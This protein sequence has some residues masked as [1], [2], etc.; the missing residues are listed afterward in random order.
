MAGQGKETI[1]IS[2]LAL[3]NGIFKL[4]CGGVSKKSRMMG[5]Y[6]VRFYERF[7]VKFP[8]ST[9]HLTLQVSKTQ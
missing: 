7:G 3:A 8:L 5:D 1:S 9:R 6:R 4:T 2:F